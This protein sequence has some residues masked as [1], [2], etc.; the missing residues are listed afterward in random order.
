MRTFQDLYDFSQKVRTGSLVPM[1][2]D[3]IAELVESG[4]DGFDYKFWDKVRDGYH[5]G[6]WRFNSKRTTVVLSN[7]YK[8]VEISLRPDCAEV[9]D[10]DDFRS[11]KNMPIYRFAYS[12]N[13]TRAV[14]KTPIV[15]KYLFAVLKQM[16]DKEYLKWEKGENKKA[17]ERVKKW[18]ET[19]SETNT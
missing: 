10:M 15:R 12:D 18:K 4:N 16:N 3:D 17:A 13:L 19:R 6:V 8:S 7:G 1:H 2:N 11:Y 9:R 14:N 5:L